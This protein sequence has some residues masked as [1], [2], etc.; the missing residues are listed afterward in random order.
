MQVG[1][2]FTERPTSLGAGA[3]IYSTTFD[4]AVAKAL[5][6]QSSSGAEGAVGPGENIG[7]S[8]GVKTVIVGHSM[9]ASAAVGLAATLEQ[10]P[11][12]I[13]LV[14]I[15]PAIVLPDHAT[16]SPGRKTDGRWRGRVG[17]VFAA[18]S[19]IIAR[20]VLNSLA[21]LLPVLLRPLVYSKSFWHRGLRGA[22]SSPN[23]LTEELVFRYQL[24]ASVKRWDH[25]L[26]EFVL[27]K[28]RPRPN[29]S[30]LVRSVPARHDSGN[31]DGVLSA[32]SAPSLVSTIKSRV[33]QGLRVQVIHGRRDKIVPL[34]NSKRL[35]D[36]MFHDR[37]EL[38]VVSNAGHIPHEE[39]PKLTSRI[40]RDFCCAPHLAKFGTEKEWE[41]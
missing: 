41:G 29:P 4:I 27:A 35:V 12:S 2:G 26:V 34:S 15:C 20:G 40:I 33:D 16:E 32:L 38:N 37:A 10:P 9:G 19:E 18:P 8:A 31:Q 13:A 23:S 14:L 25:G 24:P 7:D 22:V 30:A 39:H 11:S 17:S 1:F 21:A 6:R 36:R 5:L 28:A 3:S